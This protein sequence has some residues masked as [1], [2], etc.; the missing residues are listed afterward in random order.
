M[1]YDGKHFLKDGEDWDIRKCPR[2]NEGNPCDICEKYFDIIKKITKESTEDEKKAIKK[3]ADPFKSSITF[4]IPVIDRK[5]EEL[6][7]FQTKLS[8]RRYFE[9]EVGLGTNILERDFITIRTENPGPNYYSTSRVD[10]AETRPLTEKEREAI[11]EAKKLN[12][13]EIVGGAIDE[14]MSENINVDD[15]PF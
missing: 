11:K 6:K 12:L 10:S 5:T 13:A 15:I 1:Y 2:I 14:K 4:Y 8:V 7:I 9:S 3:Q